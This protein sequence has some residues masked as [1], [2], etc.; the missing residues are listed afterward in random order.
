MEDVE[1]SHA[2]EV[3]E[4]WRAT[5]RELARDGT[6]VD[7]LTMCTTGPDRARRGGIVYAT[8]AAADPGVKIAGVFPED[9]QRVDRDA[10]GADL[11]R[12][13][14]TTVLPSHLAGS[15]STWCRQASHRTIRRTW[16]EAAP[17]LIGGP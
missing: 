1:G 16:V 15:G 2:E 7:P 13:S 11:C 5:Y 6:V 14:L 9:T 8:D 17:S 12:R 4:G 10:G 3:G